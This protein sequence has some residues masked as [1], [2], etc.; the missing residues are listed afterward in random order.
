M[1]EV[2]IMKKIYS[3][4][5]VIIFLVTLVVVLPHNTYVKAESDTYGTLLSTQSGSLSEDE[6]K[7]FNFSVK[8]ESLV[9]IYFIGK[10]TIGKT[11][12]NL[13][14]ELFNDENS[15][16]YSKKLDLSCED[17]RFDIVLK[18][19]EYRFRLIGKEYYPNAKYCF[20]IKSEKSLLKPQ[21]GKIKSLKSKS[22]KFITETS[23]K[24][25]I[26]FYDESYGDALIEIFN[27]NKKL[28][29]TKCI[30]L[31]FDYKVLTLDLPADCYIIKLY[32]N[33]DFSFDYSFSV[34]GVPLDKK[35]T[36]PKVNS[37]YAV[38]CKY[39]S[40]VKNKS[41]SYTFSL[42]RKSKIY[43]LFE[44]A[45]GDYQ[46]AIKKGKNYIQKYQGEL[47]TQK[48]TLSCFLSKGKYKIIIKAKPK[49][50]YYLRV[51][52]K[53]AKASD[54]NV[55]KIKTI[56]K[57]KHNLKVKA[58][59]KLRIKSS[60]T[61]SIIK[62]KSSNKRIV[63]V[64]SEGY[65]Y[66]KKLGK[67]KVTAKLYKGNKLTYS[68]VVNKYHKT[69]EIR[70]GKK[71]SIKGMF[72]YCGAK[73]KFYSSNKKVAIVKNK[74]IIAKKQGT[75]TI[76]YKKSGIKYSVKI[77]ARYK[78]PMAVMYISDYNTRNNIITAWVHNDGKG[79]MK[80][81]SNDAVLI[82]WDYK[83][84][85]RDLHMTGNKKSVTIKPNHGRY[86][87]FKVEGDTTYPGENRK[88]IQC[89]MNYDGKLYWIA[90]DSESGYIWNKSKY[91]EIPEAYDD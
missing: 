43:I 73:G 25:H 57:K 20:N 11:D 32:E 14:I 64:D 12:G 50:T 70:P 4:F 52:A 51:K 3:V 66:A 40:L 81:Y 55:F 53:T 88:D 72:K 47:Y 68:I 28:I 2:S 6:K 58:Y 39:K 38:K 79:T 84:Y 85:D 23:T 75:A 59:R 56:S 87:S 49:F 27:S 65:V 67:A 7:D 9:H 18:E 33:D 80:L 19:G 16:L 91:V 37:Y 26:N 31:S 29:Y 34:S 5:S 63:S 54:K 46:L 77:R 8:T 24:A 71:L 90:I 22:F 61:D 76:F 17:F 74:K 36:M 10:N 60:F 21:S 89:Y 42:N 83:S 1:F 13:K 45:D 82:D 78:K 69:I 41:I 44:N 48:R 62:W 15:S 86:V 30:S 35:V